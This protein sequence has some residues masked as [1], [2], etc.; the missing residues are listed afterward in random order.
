MEQMVFDQAWTT[1]IIWLLA[2]T[3]GEIQTLDSQKLY[4]NKI[5]GQLNGCLIGKRFST[6]KDSQ[7]LPQE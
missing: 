7:L 5:L 3:R 6:A 2:G 1:N 4:L